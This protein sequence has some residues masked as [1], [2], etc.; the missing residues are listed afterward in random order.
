MRALLSTLPPLVYGRVLA[1]R[2]DA[3]RHTHAQRVKFAVHVVGD[4][5]HSAFTIHSAIW[6]VPINHGTKIPATT[7]TAIGPLNSRFIF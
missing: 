7:I 5:A 2:Y 1:G 4:A 3:G 6:N